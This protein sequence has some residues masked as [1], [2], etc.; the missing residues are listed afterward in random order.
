MILQQ[1]FDSAIHKHTQ[2][3]YTLNFDNHLA[4]IIFV[5]GH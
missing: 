4:H 3:S 5:L 2:N 1:R